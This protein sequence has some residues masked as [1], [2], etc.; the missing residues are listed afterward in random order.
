MQA[1]GVTP[2]V[3][4]LV[5]SQRGHLPFSRLCPSGQV[6]QD[7]SISQVSHSHK[8]L[9]T[10]LVELPTQVAHFELSQDKHCLV[11]TSKYFPSSQL[12][13]NLVESQVLQSLLHLFTQY[14][15]PL[16]QVAHSVVSHY[17]HYPEYK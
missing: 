1:V 17:K 4:H 13:Q 12:V 7:P 2:Q 6:R 5:W 8:H 11:F 9:S 3:A 10:Q 16:L 14:L 15:G